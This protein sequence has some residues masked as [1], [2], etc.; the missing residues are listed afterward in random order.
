MI[1]TLN[2]ITID[3]LNNAAQQNAEDYDKMFQKAA[4]AAF[5]EGVMWAQKE[6]NKP[7]YTPQP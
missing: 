4:R 1:K 2:D 3:E 7:K 6:Y 5:I